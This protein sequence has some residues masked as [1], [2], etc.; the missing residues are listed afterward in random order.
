MAATEEPIV[1]IEPAVEEPAVEEPAKEDNPPPKS[2]KAKKAA[3][4][5]EPKT[6]KVPAPR[7]R[8]AATH[9]PYFEVIFGF[10]G[11]SF[12]CFRLVF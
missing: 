10:F 1:P 5:K 9:P 12:L 3:A 2:A 6:K 8:S 7:K 11:L 4:P